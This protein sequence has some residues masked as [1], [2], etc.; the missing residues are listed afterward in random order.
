MNETID[1][2]NLTTLPSFILY[3]F[4]KKL[5]KNIAILVKIG[6]TVSQCGLAVL[7]SRIEKFVHV[8]SCSANR[9]VSIKIN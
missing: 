1:Q 8:V 6:K 2:K 7:E 4:E 9:K 5:K 3:G